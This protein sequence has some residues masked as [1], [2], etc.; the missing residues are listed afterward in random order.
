MWTVKSRLSGDRGFCHLRHSI[1]FFLNNLQYYYQVDV[2]DSEFNTLL[3]EVIH[4][5]DVQVV[6]RC[7]RN[8]LTNLVR[9]SF[10]D[11]M[12]VQDSLDRIFQI[13]LRFVSVFRILEQQ[14]NAESSEDEPASRADEVESLFSSMTSSM[15][16]QQQQRPSAWIR[17]PPF[18]PVEEFEAIRKD[19]FSQVNYLFQIM[20]R[21]DSKGFI[22]RLDFNGY[23]S[24]EMEKSMGSFSTHNQSNK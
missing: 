22:F 20:S 10:L 15:V 5:D 18:V 23:F 4:V 16:S 19:F 13:C 2:I 14:W 24:Q 17:V 8:Y 6:L 7:H 1:H 21:I 11:N 3:Q 12:T 9:M